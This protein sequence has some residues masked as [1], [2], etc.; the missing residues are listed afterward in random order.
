MTD[1]FSVFIENGSESYRRGIE[2]SNFASKILEKGSGRSAGEDIYFAKISL[3][4]IET[5]ALTRSLQIFCPCVMEL[6]VGF[7]MLRLLKLQGVGG[8][9]RAGLVGTF[10]MAPLALTLGGGLGKMSAKLHS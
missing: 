8:H 3:S 10:R 4:I 1:S 7:F 6:V 2:C 9:G 5:T